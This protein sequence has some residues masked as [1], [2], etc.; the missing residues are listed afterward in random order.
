MNR[1]VLV[2]YLSCLSLSCGG[3]DDLSGNKNT[4]AGSGTCGACADGDDKSPMGNVDGGAKPPLPAG[5][6]PYF[7]DA[8]TSEEIGAVVSLEPAL[9]FSPKLNGL[10]H[11]MYPA[12]PIYY[13]KPDCSGAEWIILRKQLLEELKVDILGANRLR[14]KLKTYAL[15]PKGTYLR[16]DEMYPGNTAPIYSWTTVLGERVCKQASSGYSEDRLAKVSDTGVAGKAYWPS[17]AGNNLK[18]ELR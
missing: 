3:L 15:G 8:D 14:L 6:T 17:D 10:V 11:L 18:I 4:Q 5:R 9:A 7:V 2:L 13:T 16:A 12:A 1:K